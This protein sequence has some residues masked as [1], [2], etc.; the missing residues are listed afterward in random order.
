MVENK[1]PKF[2]YGYIVAAAAFLIMVVMWGTLYSFGIFFKPLLAELG[3][4]R[5]MTSGAYSLFMILHGLLYIPAGRLNDK[6]GP[7]VIMIV[8]GF[9]LGLGYLLMS[10]V[11]DIWHLYLFY[12]V[13]VGIGAA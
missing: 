1:Y 11:N 3:W 8:C 5:A 2:F 13:I 9:F 10:Q 4:A 6:F 7:R 12:G